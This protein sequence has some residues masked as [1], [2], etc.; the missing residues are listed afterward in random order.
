MNLIILILLLIS[1]SLLIIGTHKPKEIIVKKILKR[2]A[3][4]SYSIDKDTV[5]YN[6]NY[7]YEALFNSDNTWKK[8][9]LKKVS[10]EKKNIQE[11]SD[12]IMKNFE[13]LK[14]FD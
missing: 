1:I 13:R 8:Y 12:I 14:V 5:L 11:E 2:N 10:G 4:K 3:G 7:M 9:P 6:V